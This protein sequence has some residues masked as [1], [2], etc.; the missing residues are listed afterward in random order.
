MC[1]Q[2]RQVSKA[3]GRLGLVKSACSETIRIPPNKRALVEGTVSNRIQAG[4]SW[5]MMHPTDVSALPDGVEVTPLLVSCSDMLNQVQ[6]ELSNTTKTTVLVQP[7]SLVCELQHVQVGD[8]DVSGQSARKV[9][10]DG[11][12]YLQRFSLDDTDLTLKQQEQV[13]DLLIEYH[14]IFSMGDMDIGHTTT[15]KHRIF[16]SNDTPFKQRHRHIPPAMYQEV[17]DHLAQLLGGGII[18]QSSSPFASP[19]VLVRKKNG[20]LRFCVDYR[21]L[22]ERTVKDSYALPRM[23]EIVDHL[24][25]CKYFSSLDMKAGYYQVDIE[26]EDKAKTAFTVGPLGF[27]QFRRLPFGLCNA[28]ATFQRLMEKAMG[29]LHMTECCSFLDDVIIPGKDFKEEFQKI[30]GN[31]LNLNPGKCSLFKRQVGYCG[32]I[33]SEGVQTDPVKTEQ[34][35]DWSTPQNVRDVRAFLGFAGYYRR[36]VK[37]FA[38]IARPMTDLLGGGRGK[39]KTGVGSKTTAPP[40]RWEEEQQA[41]FEALKNCL[42]SPPILAYPDYDVPFV[43]HTDASRDGL[44]AVLCQR[45]DDKERVIA[46]G[47]RALSRSERNYAAHKLEFLALKWAVSEKFHD[48]LYGHRFTVLTDNNPLTYVLTTAKLDAT[49]HRWLAE[50]ASYT[51]DIKYRPGK[52]NA[53]ADILSRLPRSSAEMQKITEES[54]A[55]ICKGMTTGPLVQ[56]VCCS[57]QA[58]DS[59]VEL[60]EGLLLESPRD[61]R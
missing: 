54:I 6:V 12:E 44:G 35:K 42:S 7:Q 28:P 17:K 48:Y 52:A 57:T 34:I 18:E 55:A 58:L 29:E 51:F 36:F 5:V 3:D 38:K 4:Q 61:W 9:G 10:A 37:D 22:N 13:R 21:C 24:K 39:K 1:L 2:E 23:E 46:Y 30:R 32:H 14:D 16:L 59:E 56:M 41:A 40:W 31:G 50:L 19:V 53:N 8:Q 45:Q 26:E 60:D 11:E 47:S 25:G 49:G 20:A 27:Y 33:I 43:V 15:A